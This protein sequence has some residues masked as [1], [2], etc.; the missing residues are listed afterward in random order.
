MVQTTSQ[1]FPNPNHISAAALDCFGACAPR[2][3]GQKLSLRAEGEAIQ[4]DAALIGCME[5]IV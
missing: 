2:N 1:G 4:G 3:D 5:S